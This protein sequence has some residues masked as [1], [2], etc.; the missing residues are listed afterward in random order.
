MSILYITGRRIYLT[1]ILFVWFSSQAVTVLITSKQWRK[2]CQILGSQTIISQ[3]TA[4]FI[5]IVLKHGIFVLAKI[6]GGG[7]ISEANK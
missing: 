4:L 3:Q 5:S 6:W 1:G 7:R 2:L